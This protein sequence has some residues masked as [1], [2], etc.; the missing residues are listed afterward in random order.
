MRKS[1]RAKALALAGLAVALGAQT[2]CQTQVAGMTL[3]SP[4]YMEHPPQYFPQ[5]PDFPL[6]K[7]LATMEAQS[8]LTTPQGVGPVAPIPGAGGP[9]APLV[10]AAPMGAPKP[11]M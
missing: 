10:P 8:G 3:P 7:E 5:E 2:G 1:N 11:G 6:V 4:Y 9:A